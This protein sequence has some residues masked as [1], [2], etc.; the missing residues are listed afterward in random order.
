MRGLKYLERSTGPVRPAGKMRFDED[1][2]ILGY[3]IAMSRELMKLWKCDKARFLEIE[4]KYDLFGWIRDN[5]EYLQ[6]FGDSAAAE[7]IT[8]YV[9][10]QGGR[11]D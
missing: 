2:V 9:K 4:K 3:Q 6:G 8:E 11:H 5:Y 1:V 7:D 10:E